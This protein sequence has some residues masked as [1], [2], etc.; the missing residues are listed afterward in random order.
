MPTR[1][2]DEGTMMPQRT[3]PLVDLSAQRER[4]GSALEEA[5]SRVIRHG[6][7]ILGPEVDALEAALSG[8][9]GAKHA[10]TCASGTDALQL[11]LMARGV[12]SGDAVLCPAFTFAATAEAVVLVGAAPIFVDVREEDF[13]L[14][15]A[16][17]GLG[18]AEARAH[19]LRPVGV[20]SVDL[21]G[22][23]AD[24]AAIEPFCREH[25]LWLVCDAAQS[26]GATFGG[27]PVGRI[28]LATTT[29]FFPAKPLG[30]YGDGGAV[31][32][33]DDELAA[34][35]RSVRNHGQ[36][37]QRYEHV[38]IGFN[39]RLDTIQAAILLEKLAIFPSEIEA[40]Q[41]V[42]RRYDDLI[43]GAAI[44]PKV[45]QGRTSVWG[46]YTI[47]HATYDRDAFRAALSA[48]GVASAVYYPK[49]LHRQ[50]AYEHCPVASGELPVTDLLSREV[51]SLPIHAYLEAEVQDEVAAVV[52]RA[53]SATTP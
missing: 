15:P 34:A 5:V 36:G 46:Q 28:G 39:G 10:I 38:R 31:F 45:G 40:R 13:A 6:A 22:Q 3:I 16:C 51:V 50:P 9:C 25:G 43:G 23:P 29:S 1:L 37:D 21:F 11:V 2:F 41:R 44:L 17:L 30:C 8:F 47:R 42:A 24:Y 49:G 33:D 26:F 4:L 32:T 48:E 7:Y 14:D 12:G 18:L 35:M 19:D 20:I 52:R 27:R 53:L